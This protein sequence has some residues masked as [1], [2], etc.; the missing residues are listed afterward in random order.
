MED[1]RTS[2]EKVR[3]IAHCNIMDWFEKSCDDYS[4]YHTEC[5]GVE[6]EF[7]LLERNEERKI[8]EASLYHLFKGICEGYNFTVGSDIFIEEVW[9]EEDPDKYYIDINEL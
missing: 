8:L 7:T 1:K 9:D 3:D 6:F 4:Y 5:G 2:V